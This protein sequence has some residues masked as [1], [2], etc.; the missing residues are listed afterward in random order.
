[1]LA[2]LTRVI[3]WGLVA[4]E[5]LFAGWSLYA[6][7][8]HLG[9]FGGNGVPP[10]DLAVFWVVGDLVRNG[11]GISTYQAE[12]LQE[13]LRSLFQS[14]ISGMEWLYP[15]TALALV[16]LLALVPYGVSYALFTAGSMGVF[17]AS[18]SRIVPERWHMWLWLVFPAATVNWSFGQAGLLLAA[19]MIVAAVEL[20]RRPR[21]SGLCVGL[22]L[23]KPHL[24]VIL[25]GAL[26]CGRRWHALGAAL[27][28]ASLMV[29]ASVGL[30]GAE[31]W[32][33]WLEKVQLGMSMGLAA[34][35]R[36]YDAV[37]VQASILAF[38]LTP[39]VVQAA[40][41]LSTIGAIGVVAWVW[42][43]D[44]SPVCRWSVAALAP[45][46]ASP[47]VHAYDLALLALP[48]ALVVQR[49]VARGGHAFE[50][51]VLLSFTLL[52]L[53]I[54]PMTSG[55]QVTP[56]VL[57]AALA[58]VVATDDGVSEQRSDRATVPSSS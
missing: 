39:G 4:L 23:V 30:F 1:M 13:G 27:A 49:E 41:L 33:A 14:G 21:L 37:A 18:L 53:Y 46:L 36:I 10:T 40:Q 22:L 44:R 52:A 17:L 24:G 45:A 56:L 32:A 58:Y 57:W 28:T 38:G 55:I 7:L 29:F 19:L 31:A 3:L 43:R 20:D 15:P 50:K 35:L 2:A 54:F 11:G 9:V 6:K 42:W 47:Y 48:I 5:V 16:P 12:V 25:L 51:L 26:S 34:D 8:M